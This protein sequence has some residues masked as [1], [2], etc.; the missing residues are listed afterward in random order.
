MRAAAKS[1][2]TAMEIHRH[3]TDNDWAADRVVVWGG[4]SVHARRLSAR[5]VRRPWLSASRM[6]KFPDRFAIRLANW[7]ALLA[8]ALRG[9]RRNDWRLQFH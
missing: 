5:M 6:G 9:F 3:C 1:N 2:P 7:L 8:C 4:I